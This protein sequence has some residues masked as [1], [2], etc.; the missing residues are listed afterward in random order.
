MSESKAGDLLRALGRRPEPRGRN[1]LVFITLDSCRFD[2]FVEAGAEN[3]SRPF[4]GLDR[5]ERRFAYASWTA[6]SHYNLLCGLLPHRSPV[7]VFASEHYRRDFRRYTERFGA[8]P[9]LEIDFASFVPSFWLPTFARYELGYR[10]CAMVSM[11][12]LNR[13][14]PIN[15]DFDRYELMETHDDMAR[16]LDRIES[17]EIFR[18]DMPTFLLMNVGET[19]YPYTIPGDEPQPL[20]GGPDGMPVDAREHGFD[21]AA[22]DRFRQRQL[23]AMRYLDREVFP[24]LWDLMPRDTWVV[25]TSDHGELFGEGGY[26]GHGPISHEK[27]LEVPFFEGK[28][29]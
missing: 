4:G 20:P 12:V 11:P 2:T 17:G 23:R 21:E 14:T 25:L 9:G 8:E 10:T 5:V 3:A 29:R 27:V 6:P 15:S 22:L 18:P 16:M 1:N 7:G 13:A 24:R 28:V 19:H 26:F